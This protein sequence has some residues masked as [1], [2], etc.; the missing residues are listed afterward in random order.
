M[1]LLLAYRLEPLRNKRTNEPIYMAKC[2]SL[3]H[4]AEG[5]KDMRY[6]VKRVGKEKRWVRMRGKVLKK[7][8]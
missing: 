6:V 4:I 7:K 2:Y 8:K 5:K 3:N 1:P